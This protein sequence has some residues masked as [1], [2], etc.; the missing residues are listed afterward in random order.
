[1]HTRT[2]PSEPLLAAYEAAVA[3]ER[4]LWHVISDAR[5]PATDRV[6]AYA[7]W[8]DTIGRLKELGAPIDYKRPPG[9]RT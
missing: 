8:L 7:R 6:T 9:G 1:M 5:S 4:Q 3:E 2:N